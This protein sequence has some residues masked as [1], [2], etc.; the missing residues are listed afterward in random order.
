MLASRSVTDLLSAFS[1]PTPTPGGGSAAA[2]AGAL[3]A[4]LFAM[5]AGLPKSRTGA[6]EE[7]AALETARGRL[8][9]LRDRLADLIDRDAGAYDEV[10]AA[11]RLPKSTDAEKDTR[12]GAIQAALRHAAEVPLETM[13]ACADAQAVAVSVAEHG[14]AS[15][16]SD[17]A[18]GMQ[19]L[20]VGGAGAWLNVDANLSGLT[21]RGVADALASEVRAVM[22]DAGKAMH[23]L[24][25]TPTIADLHQ[26][27]AKRSGGHHGQPPPGDVPPE[28]FAGPAVAMLKRLATPEARKA[29][30]ALASSPNPEIARLA[31]D[32]LV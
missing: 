13:R 22:E 11:Y 12:R 17:L 18:V 3:G 7:R 23:R 6:P 8:V 20:M 32:A 9:A 4:S 31:A 16:A 29:L 10:V 30:E 24:A 2:L 25:V 28:R 27:A 26:E 15:A 19:L 21:D 5:V 14:S 1:S